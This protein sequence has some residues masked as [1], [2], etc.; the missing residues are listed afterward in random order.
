MQTNTP[1][2]SSS[3]TTF[4]KLI[5]IFFFLAVSGFVIHLLRLEIRQTLPMEQDN[6][7]GTPTVFLGT[8]THPDP[9]FSFRYPTDFD[10]DIFPDGKRGKAVLFQNKRTGEGFQVYLTPFEEQ[11]ILTPDRI[12]QDIPDVVLDHFQ[13]IRISGVL[14][15]FFASQDEVFGDTYEVWFVHQGTLFQIT[16]PSTSVNLLKQILVTFTF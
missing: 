10:I 11:I 5:I 9:S 2:Q 12:R 16:A 14:T 13:E 1:A 8:F 7:F 3:L 4:T 15:L 6:P